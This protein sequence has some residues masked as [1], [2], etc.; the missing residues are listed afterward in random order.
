MAYELTIQESTVAALVAILVA[1]IFI[2]V[3]AKFVLE[4]SGFLAAL[5][6]ATIGTLLAQ[7]VLYVVPGPAWLAFTL[8]IA[9]WALVA[10]LLFRT[11]WVRGAIIGLVAWVL[12]FITVV[13]VEA[14]GI[15]AT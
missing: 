12:W 13:V 4:Y 2:Y 1:T 10:A 11:S 15:G 3:A 6:T 7:L 14:I 8:A 5:G 9:T